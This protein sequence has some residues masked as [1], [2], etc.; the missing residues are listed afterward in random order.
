GTNSIGWGTDGTVSRRHMGPIPTPR[1]SWAMLMVKTDDVGTPSINIDGLA[2]TLYNGG[3]Y[4][5]YSAT[6]APSTGT[7]TVNGLLPNQKAELDDSGGAVRS[8]YIVPAGGTSATLDLYSASIN[9]FPFAGYLK[10]YGSVGF[11]QYTSPLKPNTWSGDVYTYTYDTYG[12]TLSQVNPINER[13]NFVYNSAY[14]SGFLTNTTQVMGSSPDITTSFVPNFA[15]GQR[16]AIIDAMGNKTSYAYDSIGRATSIT[17]PLLGGSTA[18]V[19]MEY[20][21]SINSFGIENE[22]ANYTDFFYDGLG[23]ITQVNYHYGDLSSP[24][25]ANESFTYDWQGNVR[26]H[27]ATSGYTTTY[28]YD[29]LGRLTKV[30]N[31]DGTSQR[32]YY[33]D[34]NLIRTIYDENSHRTD[35]L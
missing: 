11:L 4:W 22:K 9:S 28:A 16:M 33:D 26:S 29:Y 5:D 10:I 20:Q 2:Y 19:G 31:P 18:A 30:T 1:D 23:R 15:T 25:I 8:S 21:D 34:F 7:M 13:T 35:K 3:V 27:R 17:E 14:Q 12:N 32:T 6:G 24:I